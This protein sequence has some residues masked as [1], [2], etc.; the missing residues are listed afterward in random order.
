[1]VVV[2]TTVSLVEVL[3]IVVVLVTVTVVPS[4]LPVT[5][6]VAVVVIVV[7]FKKLLDQHPLPISQYGS[8]EITYVGLLHFP[9]PQV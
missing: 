4:P 1:M 5:V 7:L 3:V 9:S 2:A 8:R 6:F